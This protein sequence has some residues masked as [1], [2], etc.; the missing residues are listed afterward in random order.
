MITRAAALILFVSDLLFPLWLLILMRVLKKR[1]LPAWKAWSISST[2]CI[3]Q[4]YIVAKTTG[5]NL[6]GY[7]IILAASV[8]SFLLGDDKVSSAVTAVLFWIIPPIAFIL[9]PTLILYL[10]SKGKSES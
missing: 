2:F 6:G 5:W 10:L 7:L 8:P 3:V 1:G 4:A 9:L